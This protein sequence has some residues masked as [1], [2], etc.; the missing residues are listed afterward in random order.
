MSIVGIPTAMRR[1]ENP[2]PHTDQDAPLDHKREL[3]RKALHLLALIIPAIIFFLGTLPALL[4]LGPSAAVFLCLDYLR[5][6]SARVGRWIEAYFGSLMRTEEKSLPGQKPVINGSTWVLVTAVLLLLLFP[7][8]IAAAALTLFLLGDA[9]AAMVG[10]RYGRIYW[11]K[12]RKTVEGSLAFLAAALLVVLLFPGIKFW[13]G[14]AASVCACLA[15]LPSG[16]LN[17]NLRVP[18]VAAAAMLALGHLFP[19]AAPI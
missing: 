12:S 5:A 1:Q 18:L 10:S 15:E 19:G 17:D 16:P 4:I 14:A 3:L 7:A 8:Y 6:R 2:L 9:V 11:G 13:P